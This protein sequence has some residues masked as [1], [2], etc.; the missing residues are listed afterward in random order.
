MEEDFIF[1]I[2]IDEVNYNMK[3]IAEKH[4]NKNINNEFVK[5][6]HSQS[7]RI[8]SCSP[9]VSFTNYK[10]PPSSSYN[11]KLNNILNLYYINNKKLSN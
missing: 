2:E 8:L 5:K 1:T 10:P 9:T 3:K 6:H 7:K 4:L 11:E